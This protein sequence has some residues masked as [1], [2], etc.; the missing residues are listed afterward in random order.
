MNTFIT[1][2]KEETIALAEK[3]ATKLNNHDIIFYIGGLGMGKTAFTQGLC[4]GLGIDADVTSPTFAIV[5]EY[6]GRPLSLFHF[7]MY[8]IEN[9]DQLFNIGFDD[10]LD[11]DGVLAIEWSENIADFF[12]D[13]NI[14]VTFEK[15]DET[16]RKITIEGVDCNW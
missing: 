9:E 4:N 2:S 6:Y 13:N 10:Y 1:N 7:D 16:V 14:T 3:L 12:E 15:L 8:R 11:Y 5:N